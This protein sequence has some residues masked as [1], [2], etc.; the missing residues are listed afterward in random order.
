[1]GGDIIE[2]GGTLVF[3]CWQESVF[4]MAVMR[5][6]TTSTRTT[7]K[8][9]SRKTLWKTTFDRTTVGTGSLARYDAADLVPC[10]GVIGGNVMNSY[11]VPTAMECYMEFS[12]I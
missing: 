3:C 4:E 8:G 9:A 5:P 7:S 10:A 12:S 6:G 2:K 11:Q 1:M